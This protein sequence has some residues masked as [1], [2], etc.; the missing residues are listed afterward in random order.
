[1]FYI[2]IHF[3]WPPP[4]AALQ[5]ESNVDFPKTG[6][7]I[8]P[9]LYHLRTYVSSGRLSRCFA[10]QTLQLS[11]TNNRLVYERETRR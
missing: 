10:T 4:D 7:K 6:S 3:H 8:L 2:V 9:I 1:M 11:T 5:A